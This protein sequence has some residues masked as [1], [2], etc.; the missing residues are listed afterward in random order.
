MA[1]MKLA[2]SLTW[3][4]WVNF[5]EPTTPFFTPIPFRRLVILI[6]I[7]TDD[8]DSSIK[9]AS[10]LVIVEMSVIT[11]PAIMRDPPKIS[12]AGRTNV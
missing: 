1:I 6:L 5:A 9:V 11:D 3:N 2:I 7:L 4:R 12:L 10:D 8:F